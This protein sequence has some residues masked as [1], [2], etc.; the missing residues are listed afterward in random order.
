MEHAFGW[1]GKFFEFCAAWL[2]RLLVVQATHRAV[3][4]VNGSK[5][6]ELKPG[7]HVYWPI[8]TPVETCAVVRQVLNLPTQILETKDGVPVAAG[9]VIEYTIDNA[10]RFLA[11][12][13]NGY[14]AVGNIA[15]AAL[16]Q[17]VTSHDYAELRVEVS[18]L[19]RQLTKATQGYL[20]A[21]GV[22]VKKARL[23]D[24]ARV[25]PLHITGGSTTTPVKSIFEIQ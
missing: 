15:M 11:E 17:I 13:E 14:E 21:Y 23:S 5:I 24:C 9:V 4:Y 12:C 22:R 8:M 7:R 20:T 2:P 18:E 25:R 19:D 10:I 16:R 1:I 3:K 6:V